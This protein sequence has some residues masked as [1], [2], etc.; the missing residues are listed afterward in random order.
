MFNFP[1]TWIVGLLVVFFWGGV[2][3][4]NIKTIDSD[5]LL[6]AVMKFDRV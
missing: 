2:C 4:F 1:N 6:H 5:D 3:F